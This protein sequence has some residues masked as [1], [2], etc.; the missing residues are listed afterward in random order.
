MARRARPQRPPRARGQRFQAFVRDY[1]AGMR[2]DDVRRLVDRDLPRAFT[3]LTRDQTGDPEPKGGLRRFLWRVRV[4]F[5]GLSYKLTPARRAIF[6]LSI[7][8]AIL[9]IFNLDIE[10]AGPAVDVRLDSSPALFLL[11]FLGLVYLLAV[12]LTD[13]V[14]VR[15]ELQVARQLQRDLLPRAAPAVPGYAF[16]H[17]YRTANEVG[18]DYYHFV[19]LAGGRLA[20][21]VGDASGHGMAAGLLMAIANATLHAALDLDPAPDRVIELV[22]RNLC[23]TGDRRAFMTLFYGLLDPESGRL[24]HRNAGHPF[25]LLR[26][27]GGEIVELGHGSMPLGIR[28]ALDLR[29][30]TVTLEPGDTL[31]LFSDGLPEA[32]SA[33]GQAFGFDRLRQLLEPG[34]E[35]QEVLDRVLGAFDAHVAREPL[36]DD[37]TLLVVAA[38]R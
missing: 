32:L 34:G 38:R 4:L 14:L 27:A 11:S 3:V 19:P 15:D 30:D 22:N 37:L 12:E 5:L 8:A 25:P 9:G 23:R 1:T 36:N 17:A 18:G 29:T 16:A 24:E 35:A 28:A 7:L 6:A 20:L 31:L 13:R 2:P 10:V 26:R 33:S 21:A